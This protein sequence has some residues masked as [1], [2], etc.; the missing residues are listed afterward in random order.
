MT[1][2]ITRALIKRAGYEDNLDAIY[3]VL[4]FVK[5]RTD[6]DNAPARIGR[7]MLQCGVAVYPLVERLE[8]AL[9][10]PVPI[11]VEKNKE[12]GKK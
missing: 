4:S 9:D 1:N 5:S 6:L 10:T 8:K 7:P 11:R 12:G 3:Q 2:F